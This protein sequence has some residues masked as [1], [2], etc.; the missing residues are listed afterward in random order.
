MEH[1][2]CA[3]DIE[4]CF[5]KLKVPVSANYMRCSAEE[6]PMQI[7]IFLGG[8]VAG[9]AFYDLVK[10]GIQNIF[11]KFK[12]IRIEIRDKNYISYSVRPDGSAHAN[13]L[14][15]EKE[16]YKYIKTIDDLLTH[17]QSLDKKTNKISPMKGKDVAWWGII[18]HIVILLAILGFG[19]FFI[20]EVFNIAYRHRGLQYS[21]VIFLGLLLSSF[22]Y[23]LNKIINRI[24]ECYSDYLDYCDMEY[25][26]NNKQ[27]EGE[28]KFNDEIWNNINRRGEKA[29]IIALSSLQF[30]E[31]KDF[32]GETIK[33]GIK[34]FKK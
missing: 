26:K 15:N 6:L 8:A 5:K 28:K 3:S 34:L 17:L 25:I 10:L 20:M 1:A 21:E 24:G 4:D 7:I 12:N 27:N 2:S 29:K 19:I 13:V 18:L 9:G 32:V 30:R 14:P 23:I 22:V 11:K 16:K 33:E 31:I